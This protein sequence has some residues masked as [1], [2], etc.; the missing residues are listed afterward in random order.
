MSSPQQI[1]HIADRLDGYGLCR[2]LE[3]LASEQL[4]TGQKISVL[5]LSATREALA[6]LT[7]QGVDCQTLDRRWRL[8]PL[9][10]VR[11]A[12]E[13]RRSRADVLHL[14]GQAAVNYCR[15]INRF[16][17]LKPMLTTLPAQTL[18]TPSLSTPSHSIAKQSNRIV[19]GVA[20]AC[21]AN[22][23]RQ[24]FLDEQL[25]PADSTLIAV[26]GPLTR[27]QRLDEAIWYFELMRTLDERVR[28]LIFGDGPDRHRLERFSRLTSEPDAIRFL[29]YRSDFRELLPHADLF[30]HTAAPSEA[31]PQ[32]VLEA[33]AAG[34][35]V[36]ANNGPGCREVIVDEDNGF[37]A[38]NN[39]RAIFAR[40]TR[41][42]ILDP[43]LSDRIATNAVRVVHQRFNV[44]EMT[45]AYTDAYTKL[46]S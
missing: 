7:E 27:E 39:G 33:M 37:L 38:P 31:V 12:K 2:Q 41:K 42:L 34:V 29:G 19:P 44:D 32:T 26:A 36:V 6:T 10:L 23:S 5:A 45:R 13:L 18:P 43:Q 28:L 24:Q 35:P 3:L 17:S 4:A 15:A 21:T 25:L 14:W 16:I 40:Q 30:W 9:V 22:L 20:P 1:L 11:L 8:D 46:L